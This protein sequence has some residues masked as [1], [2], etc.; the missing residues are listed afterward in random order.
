MLL[1][2]E[3]AEWSAQRAMGI[4]DRSIRTTL[5]LRHGVL[6]SAGFLAGALLAGLLGK[7]VLGRLAG[8][9]L[10]AP[11]L[12]L[13]GVPWLHLLA[14]PLL[15]VLAVAGAVRLG[16]RLLPRLTITTVSEES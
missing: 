16:S 8:A 1:V 5:A 4:S 14:L 13:Q 10:G 7:F 15:L 12:S 6:A 11:E 9:V 3:R 2:N